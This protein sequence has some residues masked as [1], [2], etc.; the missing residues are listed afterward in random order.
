MTGILMSGVW[1][2]STLATSPFMVPA[3]A[4]AKF[5]NISPRKILK[6][7]PTQL[8]V[9]SFRENLTL[10]ANVF[11]SAFL[12]FA[13]VNDH[14]ESQVNSQITALQPMISAPAVS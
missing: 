12:S 10:I 1:P 3:S 4:L 13:T 11:F 6:K 2:F 5:E 7:S 9:S 8:C 14:L